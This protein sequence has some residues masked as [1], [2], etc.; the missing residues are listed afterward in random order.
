MSG[1]PRFS[2]GSEHGEAVWVEGLGFR[3]WD[4]GVGSISGLV[5]FIEPLKV[6]RALD[7]K[8]WVQGLRL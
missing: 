4:L 6:G 8:F 7:K 5:I 1:C 3:V 2:P